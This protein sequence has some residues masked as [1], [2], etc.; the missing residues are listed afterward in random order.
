MQTRTTS[1]AIPPLPCLDGPHQPGIT[2]PQWPMEV[3]PEDLPAGA[4][5]D[6][7][8]KDLAGR[9]ARQRFMALAVIDLHVTSRAELKQALQSLSDFAVKEM[10]R[11]PVSTHMPALGELPRT[12]R[13]TITLGLG[14]RLF[15]D[16]HGDDRFGIRGHKPN[17]LKTMPEFTGDAPGF[18]PEREAS[19]LIVIVCSDH[20]YV[21]VA[22]LRSLAHGYVHKSIGVRRIEQGFDRPDKRE[23]LR[24][25]DGIDNLVNSAANRELDN[26]VYIADGDGE[27][28]WCRGGSYMVYRKISEN[29]PVWEHIKVH[30]QEEMIGRRKWE[31][32]PLS[33]GNAENPMIPVYPSPTDAS[34]TP[35][36][37][38]IRKVQPRRSYADLFGCHDLERRFLRRPYPFFD[39]VDANGSVIC[40]L[41][42]IA[43]MRNLRKQF[44]WVAQIWQTNPDFPEKG[45]GIDALYGKG[46]LSNVTGGYYFCPPAPRGAGGFIGSA[47]FE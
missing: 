6:A 5:I 43:Y 2:D 47:L 36:T 19:D 28:S 34:G 7:Y 32:T 30:A 17:F 9:V 35:L 42:F 33:G 44:E 22:I 14:A 25:D 24:F 15:L 3:A 10:Q 40:G 11:S 8:K 18:A 46:I 39:G 29:L 20:P 31:N 1:L 26:M 38:H 12:Y 27:P 45:A 23:F 16:E 4:S 37:A 21:N 13:V 41:H